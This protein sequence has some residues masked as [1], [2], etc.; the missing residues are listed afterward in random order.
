LD[1]TRIEP[2]KVDKQVVELFHSM[3][4]I[5]YVERA[6]NLGYGS[7]DQGDTPAFKGVLD[8]TLFVVGSTIFAAEKV[9]DGELDHAFNPIGGLHHST[10]HSSAGFCVFNDIGIL[11]EV[12]RK[13]FGIRR[14]LYVDI[15]V[16]HGDGVFYSYESD[17]DFFLY[18]IHEDGRFIYP[19]TGSAKEIGT[20]KAAGTKVNIP[21]LPGSGDADVQKTIPKLEA[22]GEQA[23]PEFIIFQCGADGLTGDPLGGLS[24]SPK[25][26][27]MVT[28]S[29][30]IL[31]HNV[32]KGRILALGGGGYLPENCGAAW[33]RVVRTLKM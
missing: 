28:Q 6:S 8:A 25:T 4:L 1:Y 27:Q 7:L 18:D 9:L 10:R 23:R 31:A 32:C 2:R 26:H 24:Y 15:D 17:P 19:G 12:L 30:H 3:E 22:F 14:I 29:L 11:T 20:G 16:H 33:T 21:L 13:S 5:E